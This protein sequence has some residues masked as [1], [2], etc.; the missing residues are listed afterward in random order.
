MKQ[1]GITLAVS[2]LFCSFIHAEAIN[3]N[4]NNAGVTAVSAGE[5]RTVITYEV[6]GFARMPV[7][8]DGTCYYRLQL[9]DEPVTFERGAPELPYITRSIIIPNH[10]SVEASIKA[11]EFVEYQMPIA[12]S[13]GLID[14]SVHPSEVRYEFSDVYDIDGFY[15]EQ[16]VQL[17]AP[18]ILRD[19]RLQGA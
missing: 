11:C 6:G 15:P 18:Y 5:S 2:L 8:I 7:E 1:I 4:G 14:R 10:S 13:K 3:I 16:V 12:P 9:N 19:Y 17:G